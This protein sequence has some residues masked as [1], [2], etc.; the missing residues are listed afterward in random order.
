MKFSGGVTR[1]T[2]RDA[3]GRPIGPTSQALA[4][5]SPLI[6][7]LW[8]VTGATLEQ[9][10]L[11]IKG[12]NKMAKYRNKREEIEAIVD[13]WIDQYG[14]VPTIEELKTAYAGGEL[15][16]TDIQENALAQL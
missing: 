12:V 15:I 16:L 4:P 7:G 10:Q 3:S 5:L 8:A 9:R 6:T 13:D 11:I 2:D 14:Y 1:Q